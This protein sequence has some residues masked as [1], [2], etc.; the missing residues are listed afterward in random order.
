MT[1]DMS[2]P[3]TDK[4]D[5]A[6][7]ASEESSVAIRASGVGKYFGDLKVLHDIDLEV[8]GAIRFEEASLV[9]VNNAASPGGS[10]AIR[11]VSDTLSVEGDSQ[12]V[13]EKYKLG[14]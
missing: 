14:E 1:A 12:L 4:K 8:S 9:R 11:L 6:S 3:L 13:S 10:G 5:P 2:E 7:D